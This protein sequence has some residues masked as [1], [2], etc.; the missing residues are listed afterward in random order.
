MKTQEAGS[1]GPRQMPGGESAFS[2]GWWSRAS[3]IKVG[4]EVAVVQST[5]HPDPRTPTGTGNGRRA[6][7]G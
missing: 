6:D 5:L 3:V 1:S 2:L 4:D 7:S